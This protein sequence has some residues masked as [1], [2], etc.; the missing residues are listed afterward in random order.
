MKL[1]KLSKWAYQCLNEK[2]IGLAIEKIDLNWC[3]NVHDKKTWVDGLNKLFQLFST[4]TGFSKVRILAF[5]L[6]VYFDPSIEAVQCY[7]LK[8][9]TSCSNNYYFERKISTSKFLS[10]SFNSVLL[11]LTLLVWYFSQ[12]L[13]NFFGTFL[14][15]FLYF[16]I[17]S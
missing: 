11:D 5:K 2:H 4:L 1:G 14:V 9:H 17:T 10:T 12:L 7:I 3:L 6:F 16:S 8:L 15:L 13:L